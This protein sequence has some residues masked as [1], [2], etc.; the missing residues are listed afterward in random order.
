MMSKAARASAV[1][2]CTLLCHCLTH[3][4]THFHFHFHF[5]LRCCCCLLGLRWP[6]PWIQKGI[7]NFCKSHIVIKIDFTRKY[8]IVQKNAIF[9]VVGKVFYLLCSP[10]F[11][12][13][14]RPTPWDYL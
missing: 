14:D 3:S 8:K 10:H 11:A 7:I 1:I 12:P 9:V 13:V 6:C 2:M 4:L 5:L